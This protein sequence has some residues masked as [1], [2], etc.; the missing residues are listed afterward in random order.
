MDRE[1]KLEMLQKLDEKTL[2]KRFL[3]PLFSE[4]MECKNV[5]YTHGVLEF[6]KD[7]IYYTEDE[8]GNRKYTGIQ[9]KTKK[10]TARSNST[11]FRQINEAFGGPF[12]DLS[13]GKEKDL[14][15]FVLIT[16][17]EFTEGAKMSLSRSLKTAN[18]QKV[19]TCID[20]NQLVDLLDKHFPSAFW[21]EYDY[22]SKYFNAITR[23][24]ETIKD[25]SAIRQK[26]PV[27]LEEIYVSLGLS[28]REAPT[29]EE[30]TEKKEWIIEEEKH[31]KEQIY[32]ADDAVKEFDRLVIVGAPGSGKTTLLKHLALKSCKENLEKQER[33]LVPVLVELGRFS[34]SDRDLRQ[35]I[36]DVFRKFDFPEAKDFI[37]KDLKE[38][39]CQLLLDGFDELATKERQHKVTE[40]IEEFTRTYPRN[41]FIV[42]SRTAGY[43]DELRSFQKLELMEFD[44][45]QMEKFITNWFGRTNP[46][47]A[48]SMS[49]L[50]KEN[51][52]MKALARNPLI[53]TIIAIIYEGKRELPQ[54][55][56]ELYE[57]CI[58]VLLERW[59]EVRRIEN[60]YDA[61]AK[62]KILRKL[63]LEAHIAEKKMLTKE[64]LLRKFSGYLPEVNIEKEKAEDVLSE[65]F[66]R[67][68]LLK[69]ISIDVYGFLHSSFQEYLAAL[70]LKERNDYGMLLEHL[71][72]PWWEE[73]ILFFAGFDRDA[74][75]LI[76][77][78]RKRERIDE[79]FKEDIFYSNLIL[80]GKCI[81]GADFTNK[82]MRNEIVDGLWHLYRTA[83][84]LSL[85][86]RAINVLALIKPDTVIELLKGE[87]KDEKIDVRLNA[88]IALGKIGSEEA[89][90][91][92]IEAF[93]IDE[94]R[95]VRER[96]ADALGKIGSE[97]A[98][99]FLIKAL[100]ISESS[101]VRLNAVKTLEKIG[102]E[103]A[104]EPLI[105]AFAD[106]ESG[107]RGR[108]AD[109][110]G[111]IGSEKAVEPL[112]EALTTDEDKSLRSNAAD[113]LGRIGS[114]KAVEPL[115]KALTTDKFSLVRLNAA[116]AL[117][118]IGGEEVV[119][120]LV[121]V[122]ATDEERHVRKFAADALGRIGS[123]EAV[124]SLTKT[125]TINEEIVVR[126]Y[127]ADALS[128]TGS[129]EAVKSLTK[130]LT[131]N[132][133]SFFRKVVANALGKIGSEKAVKPLIE[134]LT[135]DE[136]S[137]VRER[138][139]DALGKIGSEKAVEPLIK[140]LIA[141]ESSNVRERVANALG[142]IGSEKAVEPLI[143][144]LADEESGIR[145][146]VADALGKIGSEK[147]V[148]P[149]IKTLIADEE[150]G[151][152]ERVADALGKIGSEKAIKPLRKA[153]E[154]EGEGILG[155]VKDKAFDSLEKISRRT[156]K[157]ITL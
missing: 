104:V 42:T 75:E 23:E 122:L 40:Q 111:K 44:D 53:L 79:K 73:V 110:L 83:E 46:E 152:R 143:K 123:E 34:E 81:V 13:D 119:K 130:T 28:E 31:K 150:S 25:V 85:R 126:L 32:D 78:I 93:T 132:E 118:R 57:L 58:E 41:R 87:L 5:Q 55:R 29:E 115:V 49:K 33:I 4:G 127:A 155:K 157:K 137:S 50:V 35:Y 98:V 14:D 94:E 64:E 68:A 30:M 67:N 101:F 116:T 1:E 140:T 71:Y 82:K 80:L 62:E 12:T 114:E 27:L 139:A 7:I 120:P 134:A 154:D 107:V 145:E 52:R 109:A 69:E 103:K 153:L 72:E 125:L 26:E 138:V 24:F 102:S 36:D 141:D 70:E 38:G 133:G 100:S 61:K 131:I 117:G 51:E 124:K 66:E 2:T 18:L 108:V 92:L 129:E 121:K 144:A 47:K 151:V 45:R 105:K 9:V 8:F 65:I 17:H 149:L 22:F 60:K 77:E 74:T 86:E 97:K 96:A 21:E 106:E 113:A 16:S 146:R 11:I 84:F 128:L 10:I 148:E 20:G 48:K 99:E 63:A 37:E 136:E 3:I 15:R 135:T 43:N 90:E 59:D 147:A 156:K 91:P 142:K 39:K 56:V 112:I 54:R 95:S 88:A 19:V 6:G 89:V 76:R